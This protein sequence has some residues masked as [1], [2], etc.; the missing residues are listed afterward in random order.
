MT[1]DRAEQLAK[2]IK[3]GSEI[4]ASRV[5]CDRCLRTFPAGEVHEGK[6]EPC[7]AA[8]KEEHA[9][10]TL[11]RQ[12]FERDAGVCV[13]C[14]IDAEELRRELNA[15]K[16]AAG[17]DAPKKF[18]ARV[19]FFNRLGFNKKALEDPERTLW[20]A[21][22]VRSRVEGGQNDVRNVVTKC[23]RCHASETGAFAASRAAKRKVKGRRFGQ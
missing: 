11:R 17:P 12:A 1:P 3:R 8:A 20:E 2:T 22:H 10:A 7:T 13:E 6:C 18:S 23:I 16:V 14:G 9:Q 21:A 4:E 19:H 5:R 15:L